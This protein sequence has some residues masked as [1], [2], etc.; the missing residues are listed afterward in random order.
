MEYVEGGDLR[1][2][3]KA[4]LPPSQALNIVS[5]VSQALACAHEQG[6]VHR[7]VKPAN[8]LFRGDGT[9]LLG[10]FGIAKQTTADAELTSTGAILGSPFYMSPEQA[11]GQRVDGRTDIYSLGIILYEMLTGK[12]PYQGDSA[13]KVILQHLQE[14]VPVLPGDL[15]RFQPLLNRMMA[16][17]RNLRVQHAAT[18]VRLVFDFQRAECITTTTLGLD[19]AAERG[20]A[21]RNTVTVAGRCARDC[22]RVDTCQPYLAP[23]QR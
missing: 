12:R 1:G 6:I 2:R 10:D 4:P 16:K 14:P 23:W 15:S 5:G 20:N 13:V 19:P 22:P 11:E 21:A 9:T 18:L 17:D 8:I 7:D 3:L